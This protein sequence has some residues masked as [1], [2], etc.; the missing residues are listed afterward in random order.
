M[1]PLAFLRPAE[2]DALTISA[3]TALCVSLLCLPPG[4]LVAWWLARKRFV[5]KTILDTVVHLPLVLPPV[6]VGYA[7]LSVLGREGVIGSLFAGIG[8]EIA[9]TPVAVVIAGATMGFPLLV[10]SARLAFEAVDPHLEDA[11]RTLGKGPFATWWRVSLPIAAPGIAAGTVL[12]FARALGEFGATITFAGNIA[13]ETRTL[14]LLIHTDLQTPGG[15]ERL[16][17][18]VLLS[19]AISLIALLISERGARRIRRSRAAM[20]GS[21]TPGDGGAA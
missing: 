8:L 1:M 9:F 3:V 12:C 13:G 11:A 20:Q 6:V 21:G 7:L 4:V 17:R 10:R 16:G 5:G 2:V 18:L 14:P 15:E 19:I